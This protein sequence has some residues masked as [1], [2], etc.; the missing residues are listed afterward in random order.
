LIKHFTSLLSG[1][2]KL[3]NGG[4]IIGATSG[5]NRP[6]VPTFDICLAKDE[7]RR[8]LSSTGLWSPFI[9]HDKL[10]QQVMRTVD[11]W[12]LDGID[13][14]EA[15]GIIDY[16]AQSGMLRDTVT[17]NLVSEK[18]AIAGRGIIGEIERATIRMR[19]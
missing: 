18:W 4:M 5:S 17:D 3:P 12:Y 19:V 9:A 1:E 13:R 11:V 14:P 15:R 7:T 8:K 6:Q 10:V 2:I 16:Y